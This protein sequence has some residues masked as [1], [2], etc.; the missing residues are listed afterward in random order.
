MARVGGIVPFKGTIGNISFYKTKAGNLAREKGGVD[1]SRIAK[2]PAFE[3]T[4]ENG[5]EFG[6]AGKANK[7]LR[8][9]LRALVQNAS[10]SYVSGR[11]TSAFLKVIQADQ[12][13]VRG[14]RNVIDGEVELLRGFEFNAASSLGSTFYAPYVATIDRA[15]GTAT[16]NVPAFIP[17]NMIAAPEG[18]THYK[19]FVGGAEID[20]EGETFVN[21]ILDSGELPLDRVATAPIVLSAVVTANST[22]PLFL[23]LGIEFFQRVNNGLYSLFNGAFNALSIVAVSGTA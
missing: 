1:G 5:E 15:A 10:D 6:R 23:A 17:N 11:L 4:R 16:I 19:I 12:V 13:S 7:L 2:D 18:A 3:R 14:K 20:F 8:T 22:R 21:N 9:S